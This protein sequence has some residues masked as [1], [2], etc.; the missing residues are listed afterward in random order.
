MGFVQHQAT[1]RNV[2]PQTTQKVAGSSPAERAKKMPLFAGQ[3]RASEEPWSLAGALLHQPL[4]QRAYFGVLKECNPSRRPDRRP[5]RGERASMCLGLC[6]C[7]R[8]QDVS[9]PFSDAAQAGRV[10]WRRFALDRAPAPFRVVRRPVRDEACGLA[11]GSERLSEAAHPRVD[12]PGIHERV[13]GPLKVALFEGG[14]RFL[15]DGA[16]GTLLRLEGLLAAH[17]GRLAG[18][19]SRLLRMSRIVIRR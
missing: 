2:P 3:T 11:S 10:S 15:E 7:W 9:A 18:R 8:D 19:G 5:C 17:R 14:G 12:R 13:L 1:R 6:R 16:A 4:H